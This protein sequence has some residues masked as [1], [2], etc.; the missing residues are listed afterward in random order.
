M[1]RVLTI[2]TF[3]LLHVGHLELFQACRRLADIGPVFVG[4]NTDE[5]VQRFKPAPIIPTA[6]RYQ[7]VK[8]ASGATLVLHNSTAGRRMIEMTR[9]E[10]IVIGDDWLPAERYYRQIDVDEDFLTYHGIRVEFVPRT[11]GQSTSRIKER[12][13][14]S[15]Q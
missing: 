13:I 3:D 14:L 11:T 12:V 6:E 5:F 15:A 4:V 10:I 7:L 9:P 8:A 1:S 2:G